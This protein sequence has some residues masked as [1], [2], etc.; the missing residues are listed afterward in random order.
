MREIFVFFV[1]LTTSRIGNLTRL[2]H[3]LIYV[4]SCYGT[5]VVLYCTRVRYQ[6]AQLLALLSYILL[7]VICVDSERVLAKLQIEYYTPL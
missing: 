6:I 7:S 1:Q 4:A 3:T 5:T 2:I